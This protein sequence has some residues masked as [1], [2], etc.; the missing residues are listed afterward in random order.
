MALAGRHLE[1]AENSAE[2]VKEHESVT[3]GFIRTRF[4]PE[5]NGYLHVGHA[6]SM[7]MNFEGAFDK[8]KVEKDKRWTFLRFDDTNPEAEEIEYIDSIQ[9][10]LKWLGWVPSKVTY[11]SDYFPQ[12]YE[13][14]LQLIR[15]GD[16]Y[17][18]HQTKDEIEQ[19]RN[20]LKVRTAT[21]EGRSMVLG[22]HD[23]GASPF[24]NRSVEDNL[25]EFER[26]RRGMYKE[27]EASLRLKFDLSSPNPNL[28]DPVAYRVRYKAHPHVGDKWC[29][30]PTYDYTHC[31]VD[32]LEHID[33]SI[34]TLEFET[35]RESYYL[36]L[37]KLNLWKPQVYEFARLCLTH[38]LLSKRKLKYL[39]DHKHV[40][41]WNDPRLATLSG[42]RRLGMTPAI[43]NGF[44][45]EIGVTR[46]QSTLNM[47]RLHSFARNVLG[48]IA[49][50]GMAVLDPVK[51]TIENYDGGIEIRSAPDFPQL[52]KEEGHATHDIVFGKTIYIDRSDFRMED[53]SDYYGLAPNKEVG[54][55]YCYHI[56]CTRVLQ[57][58]KGN[59]QEIF[60]NVDLDKKNKPKGHI[61][62]VAFKENPKTVQVRTYNYLFND[63]NSEGGDSD[64]WVATLNPKSE[65]V[66]PKAMVDM[67]VEKYS[68]PGDC[69][70]FERIG[71]FVVDED[72]KPGNV[73]FNRTVSLREVNNT[74]I[75]KVVNFSRKEEQ[76]RQM[77]DKLARMSLNPK[78]MFRKEGSKYTKYDEDGIPTHNAEGEPFS[79][80]QVKKFKKEWTKQKKLFEKNN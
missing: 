70:Q 24:R 58:K 6:K 67:S 7:N 74:S 10:D 43:L 9:F 55:K 20:V 61:S 5:P 18:C 12:M 11:S 26:M 80:S 62:W 71:Y 35:R 33:Y 8:L 15:Q 21:E 14:A 25:K 50:R 44:C 39:V 68:T 60:A 34:C 4:P 64:S 72:S 52:A 27:K 69:L 32:S 79:K 54:L 45:T 36:L 59:V 29:I 75:E 66:Y 17:V 63:E 40:R 28:W 41:G 22:D 49:P 65:V 3:N 37:H 78:N 19:C 13:F 76:D 73:V 51:V 42:L 57:D 53:S 56:T 16:A 77:R 48:D 47:E 31:I 23:E 38:T 46:V 30:Y 1:I 2:K